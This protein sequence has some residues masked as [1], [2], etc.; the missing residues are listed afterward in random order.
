MK[1]VC[2]LFLETLFSGSFLAAICLLLL[3]DVSADIHVSASCSQAD[4]Q[5]AIDLASP[6]DTV[7]VVAGTATWTPTASSC[8]QGAKVALC[9]RRGLTLAGG[10]GGTT[11]ITV[12]GTFTYGAV[13]YY[14]DATAQANN[15]T[16]ELTGFTFNGNNENHGYGLVSVIQNSAT[17]I[18]SN[19]KI[20]DNIFLNE[21][22]AITINGPVFGV[23]WSNTFD[24]VGCTIKV[25]GMDAYSW[26]LVGKNYGTKENFFFEDNTI[27]F[28]TPIAGDNGGATSGQGGS[29]VYRYNTHDFTNAATQAFWDMHGLQ[30]MTNS[31]G[32]CNGN[33]PVGGTCYTDVC[34]EQ[35]ATIKAEY[36]GNSLTNVGNTAYQW[37]CARGR[38]LLMFNNYL[39]GGSSPSIDYSQYSCDA[40]QKPASPAYSQHVQNTYIWN[41]LANGT[42]KP[43]VKRLDYCADNVAD[44][45]YAITENRDYYNYNASFDGTS[46][47]GCGTLGDRPK[48][49][50]AGVGYWATDQSCSDVTGMVG[51]N[52]SKPM[53]DTLYKCTATNVWTAWYTPYTYPHPL[54]GSIV[55]II[56]SP[57]TFSIAKNATI[58][59]LGTSFTIKIPMSAR[60]PELTI[61]NLAGRKVYHTAPDMPSKKVCGDGRTVYDY[62]WQGAYSAGLYIVYVY[63]ILPEGKTEFAFS[64]FIVAR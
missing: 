12:T 3:A 63:W 54:R 57:G 13:Q 61:I 23:A 56:S 42:N 8:F 53:C 2:M 7:G 14:P 37:M 15:D 27:K 30:S 5:A 47:V 4:V 33:C 25:E 31:P 40:C 35:W 29:L 16:F 28:S 50:T 10:I 34:C 55:N 44:T 62:Q 49:C 19:V 22:H 17:Y 48:T 51:S 9:M 24:R 39:T 43:M 6:G 1:L 46:G 38:Q 11:T 20:H 41:N 21:G 60:A 58:R 36:Y 26:N 52:P 18:L 59:V 64:T 45:P 32:V